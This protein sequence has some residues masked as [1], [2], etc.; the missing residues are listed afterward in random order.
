MNIID[1]IV[2]WRDPVRGLE[3]LRARMALRTFAE[4]EAAKPSRSRKARKDA[5]SPNELVQRGAAGLRAHARWLDQNHDLAHGALDKLVNNVVGPRGI[6]VEP[7]PRR[8][9]GTIHEEYAKTLRDIYAKHGQRPE[10]TWR[11]TR[12]KSQRL[13]ARGWFRDGDAFAQQV[14]GTGPGIQH[15]GPIPY[16]LELFESDLVPIDYDDV[17]KKIYQG[18]ERNDWGRPLAVWVYKTTPGDSLL[19]GIVKSDLKRVPWDRMLHV[20]TIERIGQ[21][22]GISRFASVITRLEDLKDYE[23]SERVAAKIAAMLTAYVKK[24]DPQTYNV[25]TAGIDAEG[26]KVAREL[27]MSPGMI[28]DDL[29]PGEDIGMIDS[30]RP[31]PNAFTW[32]AGQLR[33]V[34]A[35]LGPSF[36]SLSRDYNGTYSAQR[37]ELVESWVDYAVLTDDFVGMWVQ[38]DYQTV[39]RVAALSGAAPIPRDVIPET[40][41][42]ALYVAQAMPW[43][44][45]L[46]EAQ[47]WALLVRCGFASEVE[48]IRRRGEAPADVLEQVDFWRKLADKKGLIFYSNAANDSKGGDQSAGASGAASGGE[49]GESA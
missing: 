13:T 43:I 38:P 14:I 37:Q 24:G 48:A 4:Y 29:Y 5:L 26:N 46:K 23:E 44:D 39:V 7:Q 20:A 18:I 33:A 16:S 22:R 34:A 27:R 30:N 42:D 9:D 1:R 31:N 28:V 32:R 12:A 45:P 15:A 41:D 17:G 8:R 25:Q 47:A 3:R 40:A 35:G 49:G 2:A 10:V 11:F 6:G 36:S 21:L 19:A